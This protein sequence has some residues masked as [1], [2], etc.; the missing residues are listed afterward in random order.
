MA[1]ISHCVPLALNPNGTLLLTWLL[2]TSNLRGRYKLLAPRLSP[3]L[4]HL[5]THKLASA[6][7]LRV[8][9]QK[10]DPNAV[11]V[12]VHG[13]FEAGAQTLEEVLCDQV[14]TLKS[15]APRKASS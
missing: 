14:R 13:L 6:T 5:C 9:N 4:G 1:I 11:Q 15:R 7:V 10:A 8:V 3:H 12:I 2:D